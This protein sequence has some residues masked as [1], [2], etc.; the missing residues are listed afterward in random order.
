[1]ILEKTVDRARK[2][3]SSKFG[4]ALWAYRTAYKT[5]IGTKPYKL[6]CGKSCHS[7]VEL[8]HRAY[9]AIKALN[10]DFNSARE[11]GYA[12]E[13]SRIYKERTKGWHDK[14]ILRKDF[15]VGDRVLLYNSRLKLFLGKLKSR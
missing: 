13:S 8:K 14:H 9:W 10:F 5:P 6:V 7:P 1:M 4:D 12:Y 11:K 15:N 3:W 2:D